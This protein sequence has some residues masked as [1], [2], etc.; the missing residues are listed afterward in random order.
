MAHLRSLRKRR[1]G[2]H[3]ADAQDRT[4][5]R[6]ARPLRRKAEHL[7]RDP[8]SCDVEPQVSRRSA[9]GGSLLLR[10][11]ACGRS[12]WS[13]ILQPRCGG[14]CPEHSGKNAAAETGSERS[15]LR[16][17]EKLMKTLLVV[18]FLTTASGLALVAAS[19]AEPEVTSVP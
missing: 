10:G 4:E 8:V 11:R 17:Q 13:W 14:V 19:T 16:S 18:I 1:R 15:Q 2:S 5:T 7:R 12:P 9:A 6:R 3:A